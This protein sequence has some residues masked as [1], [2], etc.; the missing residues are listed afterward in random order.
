MHLLPSSSERIGNL[1]TQL[2]LL[3]AEF[4][5][6]KNRANA[7]WRGRLQRERNQSAC[8]DPGEERSI[9]Q[10]AAR[11]SFRHSEVDAALQAQKSQLK[12]LRSQISVLRCQLR[13]LKTPYASRK[14]PSQCCN[15]PSGEQA[16]TPSGTY[17]PCLVSACEGGVD[18]TPE[19]RL[20]RLKKHLELQRAY[21]QE[22]A[23]AYKHLHVYWK[24]SG[25]YAKRVWQAREKRKTLRLQP[26]VSSS[27]HIGMSGPSTCTHYPNK[28]IKQN[29]STLL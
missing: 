2:M 29:L 27:K 7:M 21:K 16:M 13:K 3:R 24:D 17:T 12:V 6:A 9:T 8:E 26:S 14:T 28:P 1:E 4:F 19:Q 20:L 25:T 5:T 23:K 10:A 15:R 18:E 11:S 22:T